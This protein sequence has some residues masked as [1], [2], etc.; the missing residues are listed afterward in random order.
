MSDPWFSVVYVK[1]TT[2][3]EDIMSTKTAPRRTAEER[4][5]QA[6]ALHDQLTAQV[7]SLAESDNWKAWLLFTANFRTLS[8]NNS[9]LIYSQRPDATHVL[10]YRQWEKLGRFVRRGEKSIKIFGYSTKRIVDVDE[11]TGDETSHTRAYYPILSVFDISQTDAAEG[12]LE[13]VEIAM[14]LEGDDETAIFERTAEF[15]RGRGWDVALE[16][17]K[18]EG[19]NGY[20]RPSTREICVDEKMSPAQRAKTM[21]H[22]AAHALLHA[23]EQPADGEPAIEVSEHRGIRETE[24]E[25]TAFVVAAMLGLDTSDYSI[26]YVA[27]WSKANLD[28]IRGTAANV[29]RAVGILAEALVDDEPAPADD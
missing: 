6:Q 25:S 10:G 2:H 18:A 12:A 5:E 26:G 11:A 9:W 23:G 7:A 29:L 3:S 21:I 17:I 19:L 16:D 20:T 8:V 24:A 1:Y 28:L 13:P 4:R 22:E 14:H 27:G 15:M